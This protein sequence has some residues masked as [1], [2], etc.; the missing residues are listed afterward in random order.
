[1][2][3]KS[4]ARPDEFFDELETMPSGKRE[5]HLNQRLVETV[6]HAYHHAPAVKAI[7]DKA[8]ISPDQIVT[9][10]DLEKRG[11]KIEY[12]SDIGPYTKL[13]YALENYPETLIITIKK[14][15]NYN[16]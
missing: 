4:G 1:M 10:K 14:I 13:I 15:K 6:E 16:F 2:A 9:V 7:F 8:G 12:C 11:L 3:M 5:T